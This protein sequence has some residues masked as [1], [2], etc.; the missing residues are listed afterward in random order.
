MRK[1]NPRLV[2]ALEELKGHLETWDDPAPPLLCNV[3]KSWA[4]IFDKK[5]ENEVYHFSIEPLADPPEYI[6]HGIRGVWGMMRDLKS[7]TDYAARIEADALK[8]HGKKF[9]P[10]ISVYLN[11]EQREL[12]GRYT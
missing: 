10:A 2:A 8:V 5:H 1:E 11:P 12:A 7:A 9:R 6:V 4:D 3:G